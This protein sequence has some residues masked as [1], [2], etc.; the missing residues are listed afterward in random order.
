MGA[1]VFIDDVFLLSGAS[2]QEI[3]DDETLEKDLFSETGIFEL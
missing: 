1:K 2:M 3:E